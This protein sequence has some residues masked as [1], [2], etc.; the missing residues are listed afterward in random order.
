MAVDFYPSSTSRTPAWF[1]PEP[2][3]LADLKSTYQNMPAKTE[4]KDK[5]PC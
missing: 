5:A 4:P 1:R 3:A 2:S